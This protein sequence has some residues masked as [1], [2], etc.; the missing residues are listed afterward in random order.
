[1]CRRATGR[2]GTYVPAA[3]AHDAGRSE[4][5]ACDQLRVGEST[6]CVSG[7]GGGSGGEYRL[8]DGLA[9]R[10]AVVTQ[11]VTDAGSAGADIER[12]PHSV[13]MRERRPAVQ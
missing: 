13:T 5:E 10:E 8:G 4:T 9:L 7:L 1:M 6:G 2:G 3:P 11:C 12:R